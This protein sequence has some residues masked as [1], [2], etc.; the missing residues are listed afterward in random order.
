MRICTALTRI[1]AS[2]LRVE[3]MVNFGR[4]DHN[5]GEFFPYRLTRRLLQCLNLGY[6]IH[7]IQ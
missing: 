3:P 4:F 1:Y 7:V 2:F 6:F 5:L